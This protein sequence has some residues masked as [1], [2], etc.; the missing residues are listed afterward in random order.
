MAS[1]IDHSVGSRYIHGMPKTTKQPAR[2]V[3]A[4]RSVDS[5]IHV[6]RGQKVM[7]DRDLA[8]L[9]EVA[10]GALNQAVRRNLDRFPDDFMF[11]LTVQEDEN[12]TSQS[13]T[14]SW[15]GRRKPPSA[16]TEHGVAMLSAVLRSERA[17]QTSI[18]INRLNS[19]VGNYGSLGYTYDTSSNRLY[20]TVT[21][22][23]TYTYVPDSNI[24]ETVKTGG[25]TQTIGVTAAG[26]INSFSPATPTGITAL[27]YNQAN[28]LATALAGSTQVGAYTYDAFGQRLEKV[29]ATTTLFQYDQS[30][31]LL[32]GLTSAGVA[33]EDHLYLGDMPLATLIPSTG[34]LYFLHNDT[35]GTPQLET[36]STQTTAWATTYQPF[37]TTG[38][39]TGSLTQNIRLPGQYSDS[40]TGFYQN[41]FRDYMPGWGRYLEGDPIGLWGGVNTYGYAAQNPLLWVDRWGLRPLTDCEKLRLAPYIPKTDLDNADIHDDGTPWWVTNQAEG[42]TSGNDIYFKSNTYNP[43]T[44]GGL[45]L[46]G[47]ELVHVG[48]YRNGL[49]YF[50]YTAEWAKNG[51]GPAN[52]YELPAYNLQSIIDNDLTAQFGNGPTCGCMGQQ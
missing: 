3:P 51:S 24:L 36:S 35:L 23:T 50:S 6:I 40:E 8:A 34:A 9:Y 33:Q 49:T 43:L 13:V 38:T 10:T 45:A 16:F 39:V 42:F 32:E 48:Q 25:V 31:H 17:V 11:R 52:Q 21:P 5:L 20:Q 15:G 47:H 19:A 4:K 30:G 44:P 28:R 26:N 1:D 12:L 14:S 7:L 18:G 29:A 2:T 27:T 41:G 22:T 37:G 46:L